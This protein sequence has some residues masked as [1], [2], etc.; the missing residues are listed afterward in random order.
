MEHKTFMLETYFRNGVVIEGEWHYNSGAISQEFQQKFPDFILSLLIFIK[1]LEIL[2]E[3]FVKR[4]MCTTEEVLD[5]QH[6]VPM[7]L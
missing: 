2:C 7:K 3:Y 1:L 4:M 5:D 6:C